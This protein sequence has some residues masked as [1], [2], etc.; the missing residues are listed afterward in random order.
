MGIRQQACHSDR[1]RRL[2]REEADQLDF[3]I[4]EGEDRRASK[5]EGTDQLAVS[6]DRDAQQ[7]AI[8]TDRMPAG[9]VF[10]IGGEVGDLDCVAGKRHATVD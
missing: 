4:R 1:E 3:R 5:A 8:A 10:G 7:R 9:A 6:P 2:F